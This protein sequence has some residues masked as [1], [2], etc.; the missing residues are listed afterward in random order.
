MPRTPGGIRHHQE[1]GEPQVEVSGGQWWLQ[2][3]PLRHREKG[4]WQT[5]LDHSR[6]I[7]QGEQSEFIPLFSSL[8]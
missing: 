6:F 8:I 5:I 7:R 4:A 2:G 3:D 1:H